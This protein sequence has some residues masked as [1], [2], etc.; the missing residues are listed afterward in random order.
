M[1]RSEK[2]NVDEKAWQRAKVFA[3]VY[4]FSAGEK[5]SLAQYMLWK[6][7]NCTNKCKTTFAGALGGEVSSTGLIGA[8]SFVMGGAVVKALLLSGTSGRAPLS[9]PEELAVFSLGVP[10]LSPRTR[11]RGL[12]P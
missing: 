7:V 8:T 2:E 12:L 3:R 9:F 10:L 4:V 11:L 1:V 6:Q 5:R